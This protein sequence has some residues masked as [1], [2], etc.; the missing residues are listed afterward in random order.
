M[1]HKNADDTIKPLTL[2]DLSSVQ[3][4]ILIDKVS[5]RSSLYKI[6]HIIKSGRLAVFMEISPVL[7]RSSLYKKWID[8][9]LIRQFSWHMFTFTEQFKCHD[10]A[11]ETIENVYS[12]LNESGKLPL[13]QLIKLYR[14]E[15]V[16]LALKKELMERLVKFFEAVRY[17]E[18]LKRRRNSVFLFP[19]IELMETRLWVRK[20]KGISNLP[21]F[22]V[23]DEL[24]H[25]LRR[26]YQDRFRLL[27]AKLYSL[28]FFS[29]I[30]PWVF[31]RVREIKLRVVPKSIQLAVRV[32]KSDWGLHRGENTTKVDW[33][34]DN[35]RLRNDNTLFVA[36]NQLSNEYEVE[37]HKLGYKFFDLSYKQAFS[38]L[39]LSFI[40][41]DLFL[42]GVI[43]YSSLYANCFR[44][45]AGFIR[46][47][48]IAW[49]DYLRWRLFVNQWHPRH[50]LAYQSFNSQHIFRNILLS[51]IG[52]ETWFYSHSN[53]F[54]PTYQYKHEI[55]SR[56]TN[57]AYMK[58]DHELHWSTYLNDLFKSMYG[59]SGSYKV[60]GPIWS[61][62]I[63]D[64]QHFKT[65]L[66]KKWSDISNG[67][68]I[69]AFNTSYGVSGT[70]RNEDH[71]GFLRGLKKLL[72]YPEL[73][74]LKV[75]FK[76]K[77]PFNRYLD[78]EDI[79]IATVSRYLFNHPMFL[80]VDSRIAPGSAIYEA[81]LVLSMAFA[82]PG[83]EAIVYGRRTV[84]YDACHRYLHSYLNRFPDLVAHGEEEMIELVS[85]WLKLSDKDVQLYVEQYIRPEYGGD[86]GKNSVEFIRE[87]LAK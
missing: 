47:L 9:N 39:T 62:F 75:L 79:D 43:M 5:N 83:I 44:F 87:C 51:R 65:H 34:L 50:Y 80:V 11:F 74:K 7:K 18:C 2:D 13:S 6:D 46:L 10:D 86:I 84:Y 42:E 69:V 37:F 17:A 29:C 30:S 73:P 21:N 70:N 78:S 25:P 54:H 77:Y 8:S 12:S 32:Y 36:E 26:G 27:G 71:L 23:S 49:I 82:S 38:S 64:S 3:D 4:I 63:T 53:S 52:C 57:W 68:L 48:S 1:T 59:R 14:H 56:H 19:S 35:K 15:D 61:C 85:K 72:E 76:A 40:L 33:V 60:V 16:A 41:K 67:P 58:Y 31:T 81:D 55:S 22:I 20:A 66:R 45:P 28:V 24:L